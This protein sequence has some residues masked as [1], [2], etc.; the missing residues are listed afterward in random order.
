MYSS[1]IIDHTITCMFVMYACICILVAHS[2]TCIC[3]CIAILLKSI[4]LNVIL[5]FWSLLLAMQLSRALEYHVNP[6]FTRD[7]AQLPVSWYFHANHLKSKHLMIVIMQLK[8]FGWPNYFFGPYYFALHIVAISLW[9]WLL[10]QYHVCLACPMHVIYF[11]C[12]EINDNWL[13]AVSLHHCQLLI[14][15]AN[16]VSIFI[17]F[18]FTTIFLLI[19][20]YILLALSRALEH[21][22]ISPCFESQNSRAILRSCLSLFSIYS[23]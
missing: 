19:F 6:K 23:L 14:G 4:I 12:T 1:W 17:I 7:F 8:L 3:W 18:I 10:N 5:I 20:W 16:C 9:C 2:I 15:R 21:Q 13:I 22:R 11:N